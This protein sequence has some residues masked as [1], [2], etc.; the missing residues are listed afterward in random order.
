[1]TQEKASKT[2]QSFKEWL[3]GAECSTFQYRRGNDR[4]TIILVR[5]N[6]DFDYLYCQRQYNDDGIRRGDQFNYEGIYC[7]RD[8]KVYDWRYN[9]R[10]L[11]DIGA[12][13]GGGSQTLYNRLEEAIRGAVETDIG[14]DRRN[15]RVNE[16]S[17]ARWLERLAHFS[18]YTA[19]DRARSLFLF[20][21]EES[22]GNGDGYA[23]IF[24]CSYSPEEWT[25]DSLLA[26]ILDPAGYTSAE[27]ADY[28]ENHQEEMLVAFLEGDMIAAEYAALLANPRN[29][30]HI[31]KR[32][33][34]AVTA[35]PAKTVNVAIL[36]NGVELTLKAGADQFRADCNDR[37]NNWNM[38]PA[39]V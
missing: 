38:A 14:N 32:I 35:S 4:Y 7:K 22:G 34:Q 26:Y 20:G 1:M 17:D 16:I 30:A 19:L 29:N 37:Y 3:V 27:T 2:Q 18:K 39:D 25:E 24:K 13:N 11:G 23:F 12:E 31:I 8:G 28:M 36:K 15:L 9:V 33:I 10:D 5:K 21:D 6:A